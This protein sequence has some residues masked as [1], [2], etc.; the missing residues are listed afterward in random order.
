M[1]KKPG[2]ASILCGCREAAHER[3]KKYKRAKFSCTS[4]F[5]FHP[6]R[7]WPEADRQ[8]IFL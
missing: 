7:E 8:V 2:T 3:V 6:R 4:L 1:Q 5:A